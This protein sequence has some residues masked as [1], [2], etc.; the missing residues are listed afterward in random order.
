MKKVYTSVAWLLLLFFT[1]CKKSDVTAPNSTQIDNPGGTVPPPVTPPPSTSG[2]LINN[3]WVAANWDG[4][5]KSQFNYA[6][7][8]ITCPNGNQMSYVQRSIWNTKYGKNLMKSFTIAAVIN[9]TA[10]PT[11]ILPGIGFRSFG[12]SA[13]APY[14]MVYVY[15]R[16]TSNTF[17]NS[18]QVRTVDYNGNIVYN[19]FSESFT[20]PITKEDPVKLVMSYNEGKL[21]MTAQ[22]VSGGQ[23]ISLEYENNMG[24]PLPTL[25]DGAFAIQTGNMNMTTVVQDYKVTG[26]SVPYPTN[27]N[28]NYITNDFNPANWS[29]YAHSSWSFGSGG[30]VTPNLNQYLYMERTIWNTAFGRHTLSKWT[31]KVVIEILDDSTAI[32]PGIG[33]RGF[34]QSAAS[35]YE[36]VYVYFRGKN[37]QFP[38]TLQLRFVDYTHKITYNQF[39]D[40]LGN[41][42]KGD[43]LEVTL[44]FNAGK[45]T[46]TVRVLNKPSMGMV[47]MSYNGSLL[48]TAMD[49]GFALVAG[50]QGAAVK[51]YVVNGQ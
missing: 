23:T 32:L 11:D 36:L 50:N 5:A 22:R 33:Y 41:V 9:A 3:D 38:N 51:S 43:Q 6:S 26:V 10:Q 20:Q 29:G 14:E 44:A 24:S 1:A 47:T 12:K 4:F 37:V 39:S 19:K 27:P 40:A 28:T 8:G 15:L 48:P 35:P 25:W 46:A 42:S 49:G 2:F 45:M 13:N 18:I 17:P 31:S 30:I 21:L 34:E 16:G 7:T